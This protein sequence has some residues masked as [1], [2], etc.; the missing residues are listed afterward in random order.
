MVDTPSKADGRQSGAG[1]VIPIQAVAPAAGPDLPEE[2]LLLEVRRK[3]YPRAVTG[4][5]A[6]WR[7]AMVWLT[8][9]VF[10]LTPWLNWNDRQAVLFDLTARKF[11]LFGVVL[12]PQ[13]FI[14]LTALLLISALSLFLFTTIAGRL[15]CGFTCPQTVYTEIFLW[16]ERVVEGDRGKRMRLD[17]AP[18]SFN[19]LKTKA[20]KHALWLLVAL[21][22][23]FTFVA[24]FEP[25][26]QL[27]GQIL[28]FTVGPWTIFW[29][30]F[31]SFATWGNAGFLREQ[32][33]K[34][35]CPYARFQGVMFDKD[36]LIITYDESRGDPRG[37]RA[38]SAEKTE[39]KLGDCID[40]GLCVQ[41]CPTGIDIR[42]GQQ[43]E[44]I[45][46]AACIDA[47]D[48]VMDKMN[49]PSGLI[50]YDTLNGLEN[51]WS[52]GQLYKRVFRPRVAVYSTILLVVGTVLLSNLFTQ[53]PLKV[54]IIRDRGAMYREVKDGHIENVYRIQII[55]AEEVERE[56]RLT[57]SG[58]PD[59][60]IDSNTTVKMQPT[61]TRMVPVRVR[62]APQTGSSGK[63]TIH[64]TV[65]A[66]DNDE[67]SRTEKS[68]FFVP[69]R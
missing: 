69:T 15:W 39:H 48:K 49:Y 40:C 26:R 30:F 54:D 2:Q 3:I 13:D 59:I 37:T 25:I 52:R 38:R 41:V 65:Q 51:K 46:C 58:L 45:G 10:Y 7:W 6:R 17:N 57:V 66:T 60:R 22:T 5:F 9:I 8:Q 43:Y 56:F 55:H 63:N 1:R 50:R 67:I 34:F 42:D 19:K 64:F 18:Y 62:V 31:Y 4:L 68:T 14:Y 53:I 16:I 12:Y 29:L 27:P 11:Y 20:L 47:C 23:G 33:C 32:V 28:N 61:T 44:C 21:W 36:T 24:Y 35:M